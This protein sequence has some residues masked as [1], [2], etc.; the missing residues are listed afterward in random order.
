MSQCRAG[1]EP[2]CEARSQ[3][4]GGGGR[5][6]GCIVPRST[7]QRCHYVERAHPKTSPP[8]RPVL[9]RAVASVQAAGDEGTHRGSR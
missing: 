2:G 6:A 7:L 3:V 4:R 5:G 8:Q 1:C 9:F